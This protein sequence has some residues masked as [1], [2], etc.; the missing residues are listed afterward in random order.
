MAGGLIMGII[1]LMVLIVFIVGILTFIATE[2]PHDKLA[3]SIAAAVILLLLFG[4]TA[5]V[6]M[7]VSY[8]SYVDLK[9]DIVSIQQC[10]RAIALYI[11]KA[12]LDIKP[13]TMTDLKYNRYQ[14]GLVKLIQDYKEHVDKY[15]NN[16][17]SKRLLNKN[18]M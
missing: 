12:K 13:N 2:P 4:V 9:K 7:M 14:D 17:I 3:E 8:S 11:A 18:F 6:T 15:N 10:E 16:L 1:I 5:G